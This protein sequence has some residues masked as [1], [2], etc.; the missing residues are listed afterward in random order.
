MTKSPAPKRHVNP[1]SWVI[2]AGLVVTAVASAN[3]KLKPFPHILAAKYAAPAN[4]QDKAY[5]NG[6][7]I[8]K[9]CKSDE[10][11][12]EH[13]GDYGFNTFREGSRPYYRVGNDLVLI[14]CYWRSCE[15][16][17]VIR[18]VYFQRAG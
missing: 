7:A 11:R 2:C 5:Q 16:R 17:N 6:E 8:S 3:H 18:N 10:Y 15:A 4:C 13:P 12:F 1:F 14:A 9:G